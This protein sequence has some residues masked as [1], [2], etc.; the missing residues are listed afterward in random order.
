[1]HLRTITFLVSNANVVLKIGLY[2]SHFSF[3]V[4]QNMS[5]ISR[6]TDVDITYN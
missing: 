1:M 5:H 3:H 2:I 6:K 4:K